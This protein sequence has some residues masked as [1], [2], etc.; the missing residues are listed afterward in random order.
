MSET[1]T[2]RNQREKVT[3]FSQRKRSKETIKMTAESNQIEN[4]CAMGRIKVDSLEV[5]E[6]D[7]PLMRLIQ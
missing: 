2:L 7:Q 3:E 5:S 6:I 4:N 1:P